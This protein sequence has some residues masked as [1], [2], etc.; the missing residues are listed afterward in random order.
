LLVKELFQ[1]NLSAMLTAVTLVEILL[2][3]FVNW[4]V[5]YF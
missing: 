3:R 5:E 2:L 1:L 4:S